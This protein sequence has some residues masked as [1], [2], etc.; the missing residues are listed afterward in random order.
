MT[1]A[2]RVLRFL[3]VGGLNTAF[4]YG[5][6]VGLHWLG[7][8]LSGA[9]ALSTVMGVLF[10]FMSFGA[11]VF[12]PARGAALVRFILLY[13]VIAT[14]NYGLLKLLASWG[15]PVAIGQAIC[16]P[17]LAGLS[18]LGMRFWVYAMPPSPDQQDIK[19]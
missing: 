16:L 19:P 8:P 9:V 1:E 2:W 5:C 6:F 14:L 7:L 4:S 13:T 3:A 11:F 18:Y 17:V 10:N 12:R 15:A